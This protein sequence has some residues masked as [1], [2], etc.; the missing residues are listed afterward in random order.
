MKNEEALK[1]K[2]VWDEL[3]GGYIKERLAKLQAQQEKAGHESGKVK[4]KPRKNPAGATA[5]ES[6]GNVMANASRS[7]QSKK[8]TEEGF[9]LI[10]ASESNE[11]EAGNKNNISVKEEV[12]KD[13][14]VIKSG[15]KSSTKSKKSAKSSAVVAG[16][17]AVNDKNVASSS[18][19]VSSKNLSASS[20]KG[21][22]ISI[23]VN[24]V[25]MK[26]V[27]DDDEEE[28]VHSNDLGEQDVYENDD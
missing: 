10:F 12:I 25:P 20:V 21:V 26:H 4:Y 17:V 23:P 7:K 11:S 13:E 6:V 22:R 16:P 5:A 18:L 3:H 24:N 14:P 8:I 15:K 1:R 19:A 28:F 27:L 2:E 9:S